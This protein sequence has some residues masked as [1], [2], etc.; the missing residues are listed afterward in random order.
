MTARLAPAAVVLAG[1]LAVPGCTG[2]LDQTKSFET[3]PG[4]PKL[5]D[6]DASSGPQTITVEYESTDGPIEVGIYNAKDEEAAEMIRPDK[7]LKYERDKTKG[8]I[9]AEVP[10]NTPTRVAVGGMKGKTTVKLRMTNTK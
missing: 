6:L 1:L 8:S 9:A 5:F 3:A 7:A 4:S 10:A 2:K